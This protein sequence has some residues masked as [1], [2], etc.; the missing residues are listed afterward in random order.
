MA[1]AYWYTRREPYVFG[2]EFRP[3]TEG[4]RVIEKVT[5]D[6]EAG[7][8]PRSVVSH[9]GLGWTSYARAAEERGVSE[10]RP[11]FAALE[12]HGVGDADGSFTR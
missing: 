6:A 12:P 10:R 3:E 11:K 7:K 9:T 1:T 2:E 4:R 5:A 8:P